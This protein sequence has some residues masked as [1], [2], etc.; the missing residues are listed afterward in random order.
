MRER[1]S[2]YPKRLLEWR[3]PLQGLSLEKSAA[4]FRKDK[5]ERG[6]IFAQ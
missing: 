6:G 3:N 4:A 5:P 2:L 1:D